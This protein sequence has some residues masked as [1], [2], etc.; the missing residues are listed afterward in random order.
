MDSSSVSD[1]GMLLK[2]VTGNGERGTGNG[3]LGTS[4]QR[5]PILEFNMADKGKE[6]GTNWAN[7]RKCYGCKRDFLPAV[8]QSPK[9]SW[10][11]Q[12]RK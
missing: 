4:V 9:W 12:S 7:V 10:D 11:K 2:L 6:N 1:R 8:P 5:E 3:S